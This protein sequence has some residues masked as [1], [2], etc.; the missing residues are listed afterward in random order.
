MNNLFNQ[1]DKQEGNKGWIQASSIYKPNN[2]INNTPKNNNFKIP[3]NKP[4][5]N[6]N[7]IQNND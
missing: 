3:Y 7:N 5:I 2:N 1:Q 6:N 4:K